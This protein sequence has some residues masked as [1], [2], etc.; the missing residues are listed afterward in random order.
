L[1]L[2]SRPFSEIHSQLL[3]NWFQFAILT[4]ID[5]QTIPN[6]HPLGRPSFHLLWETNFIYNIYNISSAQVPSSY[7]T[8]KIEKMSTGTA[9]NKCIF[10]PCKKRIYT[11]EIAATFVLA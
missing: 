6:F 10:L 3:Q 5:G 11:L 9:I 1:P 4:S 7:T 8:L 2:Q